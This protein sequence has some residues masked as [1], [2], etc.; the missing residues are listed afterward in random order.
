[1]P[2]IGTIASPGTP[3]R[4]RYPEILSIRSGP[5]PFAY[6]DAFTMLYA[7][8]LGCGV[9]EAD[10]KFVYE[11]GLQAL[12]TLPLVMG[13]ASPDFLEAAGIDY[14]RVVHTEQRLTLLRP[15]PPAGE[16]TIAGRCTGVVDKGATKGA[17]VYLESTVCNRAGEACAIALATLFCRGD[18]GIADSIDSA[19]GA[20]LTLSPVPARAPDLEV[21]TI[22]LPQ[23]AALYRLL[24]DRNPL[25]I[26]PGIAK[27]VGF[28]RPIL[29][30]LCTFGIAGRA[31]LR[32][33][34]G[35]NPAR[36]ASLDARFSSPVLPG[37][38]LVTRI[39][40]AGPEVRF[41]CV[42]PARNAT[43]IRDGCCRIHGEPQRQSNRTGGVS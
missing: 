35:D 32:A 38:E 27:A 17:L 9:D 10:L 23:Q 1:M 25:H 43:V 20:E 3:S 28:E 33:C 18:G 37:D 6:D 39:W 36:L 12:P 19:N 14:R 26:D 22:T 21:T 13:G 30:G 16:V 7:L 11:A 8:A 42:V 4:M 34:A 2:H 24:G 40:Q 41:E 29:H 15:L 31:I 5:Q